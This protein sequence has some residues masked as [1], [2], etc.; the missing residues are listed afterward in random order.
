MKRITNYIIISL[1]IALFQG[2]LFAQSPKLYGTIKD[3]IS[4]EPL[5]GANVYFENTYGGAVSDASGNFSLE[6]PAGSRNLIISY[7]GYKTVILSPSDY[8]DAVLNIEMDEDLISFSQGVVVVGSRTGN[9]SNIESSVPVDLFSSTVLDQTGQTDLSQQINSLAPSFYSTRLTYSDATDHMDPAA[10]RGLNPDQTLILVNGKRHQP[11]AVV[12]TLGVVGRGSVI[13]DLNTIPASAISRVEI[14]RDGASAQYGSDAIAGVINIVLK[15][16][17]GKLDFKSQIGNTYEGDG[18]QTNFSANYGF[19]I[20]KKGFV[21]ISSEFKRREA[22]NRAGLYQGLIYRTADQDGLTPQQNADLDNQELI[23]HGLSREDFRMQLGNSALADGNIYINSE[24]PLSSSID[25]YAFGGL[26][27]RD[28]KSAGDY[29]LP[30]DPGRSNLAVYPNGFLPE[31][32][33]KLGDQFVSTGFKGEVGNWTSDISYTYGHN[34]IRFFVN[35]STNA[36]MGAASPTEFKSGGIEY[37][38]NVLNLDLSRDFGEQFNLSLFRI[39]FGSEFRMENYRINAGEESSWINQ[40]QLSYPGAQ[41]YPGY[42][43]SDAV[44]ASRNN[45]ALYTD[46]STKFTKNWLLELAGRFEDYSDFGSNLSGKIASRYSLTNWLNVRGSI[47]TGFRAPALHQS[48][49]NYTGSYYFGGYLY[50]VLTARNSNPVNAAFGLPALKEETS[51]SYSLGLS[52]SPAKNTSISLDFYQ[53]DVQNRIVLS[54]FFYKGFGNAVVDSLLSGLPSTGGAQFFTNAVDT[55]TQGVDLVVSQ[56][57][58]Y[59]KGMY[60]ISLAMNYSKTEINGDIHTSDAIRENGLSDQLFDRQSKALLEKAQPSLKFSIS[61]NFTWNDFSLLLRTT[62]YGK[63]S[64]LGV[65]NMAE[66]QVYAAKWLT[67]LRISYRI[68]K[69]ISLSA[70]AN[71]LFNVY[72]DKNNATLQNQG[73]F[74]YN[75][76]VTQFGFNGGYYYGGLSIEL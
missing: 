28:S 72:P 6:I 29:R 65:Y 74:I 18:L 45:F 1:L 75:T 26:N 7:I 42:Q 24:I 13:N 48:Y 38:Q 39:S 23:S 8:K 70:G 51:N 61:Q 58:D 33:A 20:A 50:E 2:D 16:N 60:G 12:N 76:A 9:R 56:E 34:E 30:N 73:R 21:N 69:V 37:G 63:V 67:D 3:R 49:Y 46:L 62:Y 11:S 4:Q 27:F 54:G 41:G 10:L 19:T 32:E 68:N 47:N 57:I 59:S 22:T 55:R 25:F 64:Y 14:L 5:T 71:N 15:E 53:I 36:S 35:N 40:N 52:S 31:I 44:D 66:D 17:T 43:P